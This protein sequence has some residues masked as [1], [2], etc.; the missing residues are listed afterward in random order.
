MIE[1]VWQDIRFA[2]RKLRKDRLFS[3]ASILTLALGIGANATMFSVVDCVLLRPLPGSETDRLVRIKDDEASH[4]AGF[5]PPPLYLELRKQSKSFESVSGL[6]FCPFNLTGWG[7]PEQIVGP[8]TTA[9]W[10]DMQRARAFL[11][12]TFAPDEDQRGRAKVVVLDYSFWKRKFKA[13]P[14]IL[15][16]AISLNREP[17]TVIGVMPRDFKPLGDMSGV[18]IYTPDVITDNPAGLIVTG[19]LKPGVSLHLAQ[20]ELRVIGNR[21]ARA[22]PVEWRDVNLTV[23]PVLEQ[24]TG[25]QRPL[26]LL[27]MGAV[28][29]VLLIA[30]A[31]VANLL[32]ARSKARQHEM[33]IRIAVGASR[34]R[35]ARFLLTELLLLCSVAS[36]LAVLIAY[37]AL[38]GLKPVLAY[39][40]RAAEIN[41]N[42]TVFVWSLAAGWISTLLAGIIPAMRS[43]QTQGLG[44]MRS[45]TTLRWQGSL[46]A[47]ETALALMLLVGAVLLIRTFVKLRAAPLGYDSQNTLT[48]FLA[49][50]PNQSEPGSAALLYS[51]I[52]QR[53]SA[54]P[55]ARSVATATS[56]PTGG[57]DMS[58]EVE[59]E[60][61]AVRRGE[62]TAVVDIVSERYFQTIGIQ[63]KQGRAFNALDR[64]GG[65]P[66][67]IVSESIA[68]K[69]FAGKP[70]GRRLGVP[71]VNFELR[72]AK[73][74]LAE[75]VGIADDVAVNHVGETSAERIYLPESQNPVRFTYILLHADGNPLALSQAMRRAVY[76]ESPFT[77]LDEMKSLAERASYLTAAPRR[78]MWLL[79]VFAGLA[80]ILA[81]TGIYA[82]SAYV[83][84]Q[85]TREFAIR[86]AVGAR[87]FSLAVAICGKSLGSVLIG[88]AA[89]ILAAFGL[90]RLL[91]SLLFQVS[92]ADLSYVFAAAALI[93]VSLVALIRPVLR[94]VSIQPA[95]VLKQ[96]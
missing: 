30:C 68:R 21:L 48:A 56:T 70:V 10:F 19:R 77:P 42:G 58:V 62:A 20:A 53:L 15:G 64:R 67:G 52:R 87:A 34:A 32:L 46:L 49:L 13:D 88:I 59:P 72:D 23:T 17:W 69:Y 31:N 84:A 16:R 41:V 18:S 44:G 93:V 1:S 73:M 7:D 38:Y 78:A 86:M 66:V 55:G 35:I 6:Q 91:N 83:V 54:L 45:R 26:L 65:A 75:I 80:G 24:L 92:H 96:Q 74:V 33:D 37:A 50:P 43:T 5:V 95:D 85:R 94:A 57:V 90:T 28:C 11:G 89:G 71:A 25:P 29:F 63:M 2:S 61:K 47:V 39:L 14:G 3:I 82:V 8:C 27:L 22:D 81:A 12:R 79:G 40:P 76:S 36:L 60:G 9:N 51:R 4:S